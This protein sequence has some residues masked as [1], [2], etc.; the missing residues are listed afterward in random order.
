M[1]FYK[2]AIKRLLHKV[3][4][5]S[6]DK[7]KNDTCYVRK[8]GHSCINHAHVTGLPRSG[9]II[10]KMKFIPGQGKIRE[11]FE[12]SGKFRKDLESQGI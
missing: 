3:P 12:W 11:F 9:K 2:I 6:A 10:W 7:I 5:T 4:G 1:V 8:L